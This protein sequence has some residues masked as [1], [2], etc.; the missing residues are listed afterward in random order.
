[1]NNNNKS[2]GYGDSDKKNINNNN[3]IINRKEKTINM[4][5]IN[6]EENDNDNDIKESDIDKEYTNHTYSEEDLERIK[7]QE[8]LIKKLLKYKSFQN[9]IKRILKKKKIGKNKKGKK[10][11]WTTFKKHLYEIAF[12]DLY[13]KH[14][15]PFIIMR[16][17]LE[18]IKKKRE[19][20]KK[21]LLEKQ[22]LEQQII[23]ETCRTHQKN[24]I[25]I[26]EGENLYAS[27]FQNEIEKN[28]FIVGEDNN[29]VRI[30]KRESLFPSRDGKPKGTFTLT[31]IRQKPKQIEI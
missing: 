16:P 24:N 10:I 31:K 6:L 12:L 19:K 4:N 29:T 13:Y 15:I 9:Y 2:F 23:S 30:E 26:K 1:M 22:K 11:K 18:L 21:E 25:D 5:Q 8:E 17:R 14:R 7:K 3:N 20:R 28:G 27:I